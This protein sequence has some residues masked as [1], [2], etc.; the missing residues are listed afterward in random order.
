MKNET[1]KNATINNNTYY[2]C[3][4]LLLNVSLNPRPVAS[5]CETTKIMK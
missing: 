5:W 1:K 4:Y 3:M 2:M